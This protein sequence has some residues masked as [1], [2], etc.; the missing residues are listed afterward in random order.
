ETLGPSEGN[1]FLVREIAHLLDR[2][3]A[4]GGTPAQAFSSLS[5]GARELLRCRIRPL[6]AATRRI[7]D[8]ASVMGRDFA[9]EPIATALGASVAAIVGDLEPAL[10]AGVVHA[11]P[12]ALQRYSFAHALL[13]E[14]LYE[15]LPPV[16]RT[17]LH[18]SIGE[19]LEPR[20]ADDQVL[21]ALAHHFFEAAQAGDPAKAI[22]YGCAAGERALELLAFEE[23]VRH[24]GRAWSAAGLAADDRV[25]LDIALGLGQALRRAGNRA[26]AESVLRDA[27]ELARKQGPE[28]FAGTVV[29]VATLPN[30]A[31]T[32]D[33]ATNELL[34]EA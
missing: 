33:L 12:G 13:R 10:A 32:L 9:I 23:A 24:H 28:R 3:E 22:R 20:C 14:G 30:E 15:D 1:P 27:V 31:G 18:R 2:R 6:P 5:E 11:Q 4:S 26:R 8:T 25:R 19:A 7:L 29:Q 21:P 16:A 17:R 34:E